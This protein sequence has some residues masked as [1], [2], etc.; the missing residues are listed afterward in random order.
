M[1]LPN[2]LLAWICMSIGLLGFQVIKGRSSV[3]LAQHGVEGQLNTGLNNGT[4]QHNT[5]ALDTVSQKC[6]TNYMC[7]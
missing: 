2:V 3:K 4:G 6:A 7:L 1:Q 5:P